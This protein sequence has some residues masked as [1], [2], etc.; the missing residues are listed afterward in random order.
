MRILNSYS[1]YK[2]IETTIS[3]NGSPEGVIAAA[4][5]TTAQIACLRYFVIV[6]F[7]RIPRFES[8]AATVGNSK[9][10]PKVSTIDVSNEMYDESENVFGIEVLT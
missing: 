4:S 2:G 9:T 6:S 3:E 1:I 8:K 10:I 5:I 7:V